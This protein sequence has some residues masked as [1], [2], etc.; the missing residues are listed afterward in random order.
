MFRV[1]TEWILGVRPT[2]DGLLINPC[3][4]PHWKG[5][6]MKRT[7]RGSVYH[8][9]VTTGAD[10]HEVRLDGKR[11]P[12]NLIPAFSDGKEHAVVVRLSRKP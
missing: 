8:I 12:S 9:L 3:L 6:T 10:R 1:S 2:F 5:Y 4:P 11:W 7:F